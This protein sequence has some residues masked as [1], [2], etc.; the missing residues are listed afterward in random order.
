[1][2]A[3]S[4]AAFTSLGALLV[5]S[6]WLFT[7]VSTERIDSADGA[8]ND[9]LPV[10]ILTNQSDYEVPVGKGMRLSEFERLF[11]PN[12]GVQHLIVWRSS[13]S[14]DR[15][16][17]RFTSPIRSRVNHTINP[18]DHV[19]VLPYVGGDSYHEEDFS[20]NLATE[21]KLS[22]PF[23]TR[24]IGSGIDWHQ[25]RGDAEGFNSGMFR[26]TESELTYVAGYLDTMVLETNAGSGEF[27]RD[28]RSIAVSVADQVTPPPNRTAFQGANRVPID[29]S[30]RHR[31]Y[32]I[33][34]GDH[35]V[36][37]RVDSENLLLLYSHS[38]D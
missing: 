24:G 7:S 15:A 29:F 3:L 4:A 25:N 10:R 16:E 2:G 13:E 5:G 20:T 8:G 22:L 14:G 9:T 19:W 35:T 37:I 1:M 36:F 21:R 18:G 12:I 38:W 31:K 33:R 32:T 26:V 28:G 17:Y 23:D 34:W 6:A 11:L 27:E 30:H